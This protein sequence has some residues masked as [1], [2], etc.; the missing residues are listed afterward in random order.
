MVAT[1]VLI[2]S[3]G[4]LQVISTPAITTPLCADPGSTS[5]AEPTLQ[6]AQARGRGFRANGALHSPNERPPRMFAQ[7]HSK[8]MAHFHLSQ[9]CAN[10]PYHGVTRRC[11]VVW[12]RNDPRLPCHVQILWWVYTTSS[13]MRKHFLFL[14]TIVIGAGPYGL[15]VAAHLQ[16]RGIPNQD[17]S[18]DYCNLP[19]R[20]KKREVVYGT[21]SRA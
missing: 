4:T 7:I 19:F 15:S 14:P 8:Y 11:G 17:G 3:K 18:L 6:I 5:M 16:A 13:F 1:G 10:P 2:Q 20:S 9:K 21:L 12:Y